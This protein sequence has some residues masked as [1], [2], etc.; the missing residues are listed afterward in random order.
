MHTYIMVYEWYTID[1]GLS[2][3]HDKIATY[4]CQG[5]AN[6]TTWLIVSEKTSQEIYEDFLPFFF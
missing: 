5:I 1:N 3:L 2:K 6:E 4:K